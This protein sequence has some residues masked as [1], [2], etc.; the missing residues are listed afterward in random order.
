M[1][2]FNYRIYPFKC[3]TLFMILPLNIKLQLLNILNPCSTSFLSIIQ[4]KLWLTTF[5]TLKM[6][7]P[8]IVV[9]AFQNK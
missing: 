5:N 1:S 9:I 2:I 8:D 3:Y 6:F 7:S 4:S